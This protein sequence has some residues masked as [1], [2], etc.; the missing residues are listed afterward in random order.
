MSF[1]WSGLQQADDAGRACLQLDENGLTPLS[2]RPSSF[3]HGKRGPA[4][5]FYIQR[6]GI[7]QDRVFCGY[8]RRDGTARIA[9]IA[10]FDAGEN[11]LVADILAALGEFLEAAA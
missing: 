9:C 1:E 2:A 8:Q 4:C 5:G 6:G 11:V 7:E 10:A 3:H